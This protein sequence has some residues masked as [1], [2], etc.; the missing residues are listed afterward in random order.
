MLD[1]LYYLYYLIGVLTSITLFFHIINFKRFEKIS[2]WLI[3]FK[4]VTNK[5]P[6][7]SDYR[8]GDYE[9]FLK[10]NIYVIF[11]SI[12]SLLGILTSNWFI[13]VAIYIYT[14]L[15]GIAIK[16]IRFTLFGKIMFFKLIFGKFLIYSFL[17]LNHFNFKINIFEEI[18]KIFN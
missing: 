3:S 15:F 9:L 7:K 12:W 14:K 11:E 1:H 10:R 4:K 13:F 18:L 16:N 6:E 17:V 5:N 8:E 2:E